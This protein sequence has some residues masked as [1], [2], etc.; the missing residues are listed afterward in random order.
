MVVMRRNLTI[1]VNNLNDPVDRPYCVADYILYVSQI[2]LRNGP[3]NS[4]DHG[5]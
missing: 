4:R 5:L 1:V 2:A 3:W